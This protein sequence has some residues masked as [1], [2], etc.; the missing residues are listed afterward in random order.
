MRGWQERQR[1]NVERWRRR[2]RAVR[3]RSAD[4]LADS[5]TTGRMMAKRDGQ[6][7]KKN[8]LE[9]QRS[10]SSTAWRSTPLCVA[11]ARTILLSVPTR[12]GL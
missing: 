9:T 10:E 3:W 2:E 12:N 6:L 5:K 4:C 1:L 8:S 7:K 11:T